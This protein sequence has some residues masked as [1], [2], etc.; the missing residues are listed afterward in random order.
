MAE[1]IEREIVLET[2]E[3]YGLTT[4]VIIG[5]HCGAAEVAA[6]AV[7]Q[8]PAA[9]VKPVIHSKWM[10]TVCAACG[11]SVSFYFDCDYCPICGARMDDDDNG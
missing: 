9:D 3:R 1:Y 10:G 8:I 11:T 2:L 5:H 7:S 6:D 4:G